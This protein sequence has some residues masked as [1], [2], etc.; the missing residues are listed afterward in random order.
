MRDFN[1]PERNISLNP[2]VLCKYIK[3]LHQFVNL[4]SVENVM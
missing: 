1:K 3:N 2:L 4:C